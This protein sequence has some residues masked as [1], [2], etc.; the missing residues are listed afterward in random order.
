M[1]ITLECSSELSTWKPGWNN[2]VCECGRSC[3]GLH[4]LSLMTTAQCGVH[5]FIYLCI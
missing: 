3:V 5:D 2:T 1:Y 4:C